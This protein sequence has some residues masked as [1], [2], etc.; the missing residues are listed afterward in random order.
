MS[1]TLVRLAPRA[2]PV[3]RCEAPQREAEGSDP[4]KNLSFGD[5]WLYR[6]DMNP[7]PH[8]TDNPVEESRSE[9]ED[10]ALTYDDMLMA[11]PLETAEPLA[12]E[13]GEG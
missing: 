2:T 11:T 6:Q 5:E 1:H 7:R 9:R 12:E 4:G 8:G 10:S 3:A 13:E